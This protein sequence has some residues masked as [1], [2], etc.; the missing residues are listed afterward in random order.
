ME[1]VH[2]FEEV[3]ADL[4]ANRTLVELYS[5]SSLVIVCLFSGSGNRKFIQH[6]C[7]VYKSPG[8]VV[9]AHCSCSAYLQI[10][11]LYLLSEGRLTINTSVASKELI[12]PMFLIGLFLFCFRSANSDS[13]TDSRKLA[14]V[15]PTLSLF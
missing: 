3:D 6:L 2:C 5:M 12:T 10:C 14:C 1:R 9:T 11:F 4:V 13:D 7:N 15:G 8:V